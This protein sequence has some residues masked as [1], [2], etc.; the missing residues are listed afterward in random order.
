MKLVFKES[1]PQ[2]GGAITFV[3]SPVEPLKWTP[4]QSIKI[5]V[6]GDYE[7][8]EHRFSISSAPYEKDIMITTRLSGSPY[9]N[10]LASL[11]PGT[12]VNAYGIE[13]EFVWRNTKTPHI[14]IAGG[15]G[16]TPYHSMLKQRVHDQQPIAA[17]L[18]YSSAS[19][20]IIYKTELDAWVHDHLEFKINYILGRRVMAKDIA[21]PGQSLIYL[22]GPSTMVDELSTELVSQGIPESQLM[23]DWFTG[24]LPTSG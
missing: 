18:I 6:P 1:L 17:K 14:F 2:G 24:R 21:E 11:Q 19:E 7:S 16:I 22:S 23:R 12:K 4:G 9:K 3:F 5:E 20:D 15:I 8:L 10:S 13:G